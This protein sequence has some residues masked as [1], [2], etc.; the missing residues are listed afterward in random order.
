[1]SKNGIFFGLT[2]LDIIYYLDHHPAA[3]EKVK[4]ERQ[5]SFAGGPAANAAVSFAAFS[6]RTTLVTGLGNHPLTR[7]V[8]ADLDE[9]RVHLIDCSSR[10]EGPP[11]I[12]SILVNQTTGERSIVY[13]NTDTRGVNREAIDDIPIELAD[14]LL[15]DGY[16]LREAI[17]L[18]EKAGKIG[19]P[20]VLDGGSWKDGLENLLPYIDFAVCSNDFYPPGCDDKLAVIKTL[21]DFDIQNVAITR[22]GESILASDGG[23][24]E[25]LEVMRV[26]AVDTL[27][28][29]DIFHGAF[30]HHILGQDFINSLRQASRI[31]SKAC[32]FQGAR[33]WTR[34][35]LLD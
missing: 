16:F 7:E 23:P 22:G 2:T 15:L 29:G 6:N 10:P 31:A 11:V 12:S 14:I 30:C 17:M 35:S 18:A 1:M 21:Q 9:H 27:A 25:E 34:Q 3:N 5:L 4:A 33:A 8:R 20:V 19:V 26:Q 32:T 24:I 28:A 13:S